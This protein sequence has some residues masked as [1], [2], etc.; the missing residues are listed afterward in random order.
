VIGPEQ[1]AAAASEVLGEPVEACA[2]ATR[3]LGLSALA[4]GQVSG[5][6][7]LVQRARG[8]QKSGGLPEAFLVAVAGG[9]LVLL[10][11]PK[12]RWN[13]KPK[14]TEVLRAYDLATTRLRSEANTMGSRLSIEPAEG[15]AVEI[16]VTRGKAG[17][18]LVERLSSLGAAV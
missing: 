5:A 16:Q 13:P 2:P 8:R 4:L 7:G 15:E 14:A 10:A 18:A 17:H 11:Q 12:V 1:Y 9:R 3:V 6:A